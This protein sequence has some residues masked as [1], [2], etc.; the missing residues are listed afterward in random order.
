M[1]QAETHAHENGGCNIMLCLAHQVNER[2][3]AIK[4]GHVERSS[5]TLESTHLFSST[6]VGDCWYAIYE[7][8]ACPHPPGELRFS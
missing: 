7:R 8:I 6:C 5:L 4:E 1:R 2:R 3:R